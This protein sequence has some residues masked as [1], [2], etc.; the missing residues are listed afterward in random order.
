MRRE[1]PSIRLKTSLLL[2]FSGK[3]L[4]HYQTC[5]MPTLA[6]DK[7]SVTLESHGNDCVFSHVKYSFLRK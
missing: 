2:L 4:T 5:D 7:I 3:K 1:N 6:K